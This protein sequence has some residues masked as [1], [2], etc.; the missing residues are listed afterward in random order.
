MPTFTI[1][2]KYGEQIV[3][4]VD[5]AGLGPLAGPLVVCACIIKIRKL[6]HFLSVS[7]DDSKKL[8]SQKR[9][10]IFEQIVNNESFVYG[11][12][13][14]SSSV[15]DENG[16]LHAWQLGI[17]QS[18]SN[19]TVIPDVCLLDGN[20]Q[21]KINQITTES[22]VK[23]DQKSYSIASASII[24][25]VTRDRIM[26]KIHTKF[27]MYGFDKNAGYGTKFHLQALEKYGITQYHRKSYAPIKKKLEPL[28]QI[29]TIIKI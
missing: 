5:E 20:M 13:V 14:V 29:T 26:Q 7:I 9:E 10:K 18:V 27:P 19:L 28:Q 24:A 25:K 22:I 4:G 8:S 17:S 2:N 1:E 15:I 23:G 3:A 11:I 12:S 21:I 16:L 6:P